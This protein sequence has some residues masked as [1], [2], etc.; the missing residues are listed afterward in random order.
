MINS[1]EGSTSK[2]KSSLRK[3][4]GIVLLA[5]AVYCGGVITDRLATKPNNAVGTVSAQNEQSQNAAL[6][7]SLTH[8]LSQELRTDSSQVFSPVLNGTAN[9]RDKSGKLYSYEYPL[10]LESTNGS[11][12]INLQQES[13]IWLGVQGKAYDGTITIEPILYDSTVDSFTPVD[14]KNIVLPSVEM[15]QRPVNN[16]DGTTGYTLHAYIH[17]GQS[18]LRTPNGVDANPGSLTGTN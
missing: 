13:G 7:L 5:S 1:P 8:L 12:N 18:V 6:A 15:S 10:L 2:Q 17:N 9:I 16:T 4:V 3:K 11:T 14:Q